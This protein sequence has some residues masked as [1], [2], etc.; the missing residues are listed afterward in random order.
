[1]GQPLV[2]DFSVVPTKSSEAVHLMVATSGGL[3]LQRNSAPAVLR[4]L[5][6]GNEYWHEL[7][8]TP[9]EDGIFNVSL[10]A[11]VGEGNQALARTLSIPVVVGAAAMQS[12]K[13]RKL[14]VEVDATGQAIEVMPGQE[15][16]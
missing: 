5:E 4:D 2:I 7:V 16:R 1:V 13:A 12:D 9:Q 14:N 11:T 10:I 3:T 6:A 15:S 8:V